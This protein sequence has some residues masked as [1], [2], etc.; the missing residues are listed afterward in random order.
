[1]EWNDKKVAVAT[2]ILR[3]LAEEGM[4]IRENRDVLNHVFMGLDYIPFTSLPKFEESEKK[5]YRPETAF[6]DLQ[7]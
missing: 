4:T 2:R 7:L 3:L 6:C 1:M 5:S